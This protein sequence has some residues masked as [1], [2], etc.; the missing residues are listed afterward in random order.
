MSYNPTEVPSSTIDLTV[1]CCMSKSFVPQLQCRSYNAFACE[2]SRTAST[3]ED[4]V[5]TSFDQDDVNSGQEG[6]KMTIGLLIKKETV[7]MVLLVSTTV[8][9]L[10]SLEVEK[11]QAPLLLIIFKSSTVESPRINGTN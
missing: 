3:E 7:D 2:H 1:D 8:L 6:H 5:R 11:N 4:S 10:Y 9:S